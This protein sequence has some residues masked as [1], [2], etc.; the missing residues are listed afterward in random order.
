MDAN[1]NVGAAKWAKDP[2][3]GNSTVRF[4]FAISLLCLGTAG[5]V[6]VH[7]PP[8]QPPAA[9]IVTPAPMTFAS[10]S[11]TTYVAPGTTTTVGPAG[12]TTVQRAY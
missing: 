3:R 11:T 7:S 2:V 1:C 9:T 6:D 10:P 5:C 4:S 8:P 12:T